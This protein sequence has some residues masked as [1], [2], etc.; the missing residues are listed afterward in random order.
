[1]WDILPVTFKNRI[2][3]IES[4]ELSLQALQDIS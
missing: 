2:K 3:K 4:W 1:M